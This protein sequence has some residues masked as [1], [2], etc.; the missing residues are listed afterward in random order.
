MAQH[1]P[2]EDAVQDRPRHQPLMSREMEVSVEVRLGAWSARH[3]TS[4]AA[5]ATARSAGPS[6]V[7]GGPART[8]PGPAEITSCPT[9]VIA[10]P[11]ETIP[12]P[13][14]DIS[15]PVETIPCPAEVVSGPVETIPCP[16]ELI[17]CPAEEIPCP[18][19][20]DRWPAKQAAWT[21]G[22]V[23][24]QVGVGKG[25]GPGS[26]GEL[27]MAGVSTST[28]ESPDLSTP[29]LWPAMLIPAQA[30]GKRVHNPGAH[31][32]GMNE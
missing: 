10:C 21:V 11:A 16:G 18:A 19:D 22:V 29:A 15:C 17:S 7:H 26:T 24:P 27:L 13:A 25:A 14:E 32:N 12:F 23:G 5:C 6:S 1:F 4:L 20:I 28:R 9:E 3:P 31:G 30:S 8:R 2:G